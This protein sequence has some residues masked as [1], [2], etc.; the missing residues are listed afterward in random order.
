MDYSICREGILSYSYEGFIDAKRFVFRKWSEQAAEQCRPKPADLS[1]SC[2]FGSLF[3]HRVFGG[4]IR[5]HYR[6]QYNFIAG[7]IVDLSHDALDVGAMGT[8]YLHEP[9]FFEIPEQIASLASCVP[10]IDSW[11]AE[12]LKEHDSAEAT[13]VCRD[14]SYRPF[15]AC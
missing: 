12:F 6:H 9:G 15:D 1:G 14:S 3:M 10:R 11:V 4:S 5:G 8:P 2:K 7:R 13:K